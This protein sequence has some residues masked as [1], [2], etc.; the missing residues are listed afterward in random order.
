[1]KHKSKGKSHK[2]RRSE[3]AVR[4][5]ENGNKIPK[6]VLMRNDRMCLLMAGG[7]DE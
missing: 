5:F 3:R 1:M 2:V 7:E 6:E 4:A